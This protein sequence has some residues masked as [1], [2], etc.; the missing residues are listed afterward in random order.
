MLENQILTDQCAEELRTLADAAR[1]GLRALVVVVPAG[2]ATAAVLD[3]LAAAVAGSPGPAALPPVA[4]VP[5]EAPPLCDAGSDLIRFA[6]DA[7]GDWLAPALTAAGAVAA[8]HRKALGGADGGAARPADVDRLCARLGG[9]RR[10][11]RRLI[12]V[13]DAGRLGDAALRHL[14]MLATA[15]DNPLAA[16][17]VLAGEAALGCRVDRLL[18]APVARRVPR[19]TLTSAAAAGVP[20]AGVT[21]AGVTAAGVTAAGLADHAGR[22]W[23]APPPRD[24]TAAAVPRGVMPAWATR[25]PPGRP[26]AVAAAS[27]V[28]R[29]D[30]AAADRGDQWRPVHVGVLAVILVAA[31]WSLSSRLNGGA[32]PAHLHADHRPAATPAST[33]PA[34][35]IPAPAIPVEAGASAG[36]AVARAEPD[37]SDAGPSL[38]LLAGTGTGAAAGG[39]PVAAPADWIARGDGFLALADVA[40]ARQ[41]YLLAAR[42][43]D[44][45]GLTAAARTFDPVWLREEGVPG[46][47]GNAAEAIRLYRAAIDGGDAAAGDR[48]AA[49]TEALRGRGPSEDPAAGAA[50]GPGVGR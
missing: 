16:T 8:P 1:S 13:D 26:P 33:G 29:R 17:V 44:P 42:S 34:P 40:A 12:L 18:P 49:L 2:T 19:L 41:F 45:A 25:S 21:A 22:A 48:L 38:P 46:A 11:D 9:R 32:G 39:P 43:G 35:A 24:V 50:A 31:L 37:P 36:Q 5:S 47:R 7:A 20:A 10:H 23:P 15:E 6:P 14:L 27:G 3:R 28:A 4:A 30:R